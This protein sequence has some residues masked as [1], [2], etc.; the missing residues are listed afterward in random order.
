MQSLWGNFIGSCKSR[1][2]AI[3]RSCYLGRRR[4]NAKVKELKNELARLR[5]SL[6]QSQARVEQVEAENAWLRTE[7][8]EREKQLE[9]FRHVPPLNLP[10]GEVPPGQQFG[11]GMTS[12]CVNLARTIGLRPTTLALKVFFVVEGIAQ[13]TAVSNDSRLDTTPRPGSDAGSEE[14][15]RR[16]VVDRSQ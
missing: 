16:R 7:G 2:S 15:R 11:A 5:E 6:Q 3:S 10:I 4:A 13:D 14:H 1:I 9:Q 12:L 8:R